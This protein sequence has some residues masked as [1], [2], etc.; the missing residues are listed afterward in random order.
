MCLT[1]KGYILTNLKKKAV[2]K[3]N[4]LHLYFKV[5]CVDFCK[6]TGN[7]TNHVFSSAAA[8]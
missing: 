2:R 5:I 6:E 3:K 7:E 8:F 1:F 4:S